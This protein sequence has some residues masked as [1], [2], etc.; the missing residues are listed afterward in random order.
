VE[1]RNSGAAASSYGHRNAALI[2][3]ACRAQKLGSGCNDCEFNG[4]RIS[5]HSAK[6]RTASVGTTYKTLGRVKYVWGAFENDDGTYEVWSLSV[7]DYK[8]NMKPTK[9]KGPSRNKVGVVE[10]RIFESGRNI[11][12]KLKI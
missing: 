8:N 7:G 12:T 10:R 2:A 3:S 1:N 11:A 6:R 5:V 4:E 9:S